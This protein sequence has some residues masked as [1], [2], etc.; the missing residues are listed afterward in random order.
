[1]VLTG[2]DI[3]ATVMAYARR[4]NVTQIVIGKSVD[5][6]WRELLGRSLAAALLRE[7][8]GAAI[9]VVTEATHERAV[10]SRRPASRRWPWP[11]MS[12]RAA[13]GRGRPWRGLGPGRRLR[14]RRPGDDLPGRVLAAG[15]LHGLRPALAA[16]TV[17]F[18]VYNY[19][20]LEPR[21]SLAIG[22]PTD[23]L[24]LVVFWAVALASGGLAGRVRDQA[25]TPSGAPRPSR[26]CWPPAA[27]SRPPGRDA[28]AK[29]LAEQVAAAA[30][31]KAVVLLPPGR[32]DR[33]RRRRADLEAL[34]AARWPPRAGP[35]RR[36]R[37]PA[38]AP[39]PCRRPAGP[40]GRWR[41]CAR[42]GVAGVE[43]GAMA[44]GS[45]DERLVLALLEQG[46]WPWSARAGVR[47]RR[48]RDPAPRRPLPLGPAELGQPRPAHAA[49]DRAGG[50]DHPDRLR[51]S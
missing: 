33:A 5:S 6:R 16:A 7:A 28:V 10:Q 39:A 12:R 32:R 37:R 22:A 8:R 26:P 11:A 38:S 14:P 23:F 3:V 43:A 51:Q 27:P 21:Y 40:S 42:T 15:V 49:V 31:A 24:T 17:A 1:V 19:L 34:D 25:R 50:L 9:H 48:G 41:A 35:G 2:G 29:A 46:A 45:D 30:G 13:R 44:A 20:F 47:G 4:N 36:A 18:F